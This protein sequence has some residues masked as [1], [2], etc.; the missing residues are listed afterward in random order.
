[1]WS[2]ST[3]ELLERFDEP[4]REGDE[5]TPR[6]WRWRGLVQVRRIL[7]WRH[8]IAPLTDPSSSTIIPDPRFQ[9]AQSVRVQSEKRFVLS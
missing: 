1:M 7:P 2:T 8:V 6:P 5:D 3:A 9:G 4:G